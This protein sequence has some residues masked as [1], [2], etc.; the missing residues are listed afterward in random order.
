MKL[1][2]A[3]PIL[4]AYS[5]LQHGLV[6]SAQAAKEGIDTTTMTRLA[7]RDYLRRIRRGV[8]ILSSVAEDSLTEIRA[9]WLS[10]CPG[11]LAEERFQEDNPIVVS[12]VSAASVLELGD[13]TPATHTFTSSKRKQSSAAD[14]SHRTADLQA[15]DWMIVRGLP[16]TT[17]ART[18]RDL[19]R[20][21]LDGDQLYHVMADGIH[22]QRLSPSEAARAV[23]AYAD[24][25]GSRSGDEMVAESLRRFPEH[26]SAIEARAY[27]TKP[28]PDGWANMMEDVG[29]AVASVLMRQLSDELFSSKLAATGQTAALMQSVVK[30]SP[31]YL[32]VMNTI[33]SGLQQIFRS[34]KMPD[35][36]TLEMFQEQM[37]A[38]SVRTVEQL[39]AKKN[40]P[41]SDSCDDCESLDRAGSES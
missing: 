35:L 11:M 13:I 23:D 18:I 39:S 27:G 2:E 36:S 40:R 34:K 37:D 12:H 20:D 8:Y 33:G 6:T 10:T 31:A 5:Y 19:A 16:V 25:Y 17:V 24:Y 32:D 29:E 30:L 4:A 7:Q 26:D 1:S 15:E 14:M 9:A 21:H 3:Q 22:H 28:I 38:L 41:V